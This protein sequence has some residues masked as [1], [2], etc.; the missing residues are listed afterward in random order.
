MQKNYLVVGGSRGI[1]RALV[2]QLRG[3]TH[4]IWVASRNAENLPADEAVRHLRLDVTDTEASLDGLPDTLDG[5]VYCPGS[6]TLRPFSHLKDSDF[7]ED[8]HINVLGAVRVIRQVLP[9]LRRAEHG[10]AIVLF[11]TVA[12][13]TG[14]PFHAS[15]ASAKG[16]LE[17][18]ARS[19]AAEFAPRI[20][21]NAIAPSL[22]DTPLAAQLLS[23]DEK[24]KS[25][26]GRHPLK[27]IGTADELARLASF[28]LSDAASW[29]S[30]QVL[31]LDGGMSSIRT[32][33]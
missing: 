18:L 1:G 25:S 16:A 24:R 23:S 30:G 20:R 10:A 8:F 22:T 28:L 6:I 31:H 15:I 33:A 4:T 19:L 27:R 5:M 2:E 29:M 11:S 3:R 9:R 12:V 21:V 17:G 13:Q 26:A 32:F 7:L 14:M